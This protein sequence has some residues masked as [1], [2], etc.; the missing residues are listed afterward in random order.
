MG[1]S[2]SLFISGE[3][4]AKRSVPQ[5]PS[6]NSQPGCVSGTG[7]SRPFSVPFSRFHCAWPR[8]VLPGGPL[9]PAED[10]LMG[11]RGVL[12]AHCPAFLGKFHFSC[13]F[14]RDTF[15]NMCVSFMPPVLLHPEWVLC[16]AEHRSEQPCSA[17]QREELPTCLRH[18][19]RLQPCDPEATAPWKQPHAAASLPVLPPVPP[20][21]CSAQCVPEVD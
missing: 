10:T 6:A 12:S 17:G 19:P 8:R 3:P 20:V 15:A 9:T 18:V 13:R 4:E 21:R 14:F 7:T 5:T 2:C 11:P 16:R 1:E